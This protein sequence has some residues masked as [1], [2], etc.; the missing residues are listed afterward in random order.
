[1]IYLF[2]KQSDKTIVGYANRPVDEQDMARQG[3][4]VYLVDNKDFSDNMIGQKL[5]S[6]DETDF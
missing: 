1:M 6:Y 5:E 2:I 4:D 3:I